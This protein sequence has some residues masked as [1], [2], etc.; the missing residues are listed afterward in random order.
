M[1]DKFDMLARARGLLNAIADS[2]GAS[3]CA[4]IAEL[5][6]ML[7][8]LQEGLK[9]HDRAV[10]ARMEMLNDQIRELTRP[11][12]PE[13]GGEIIGGETYT[14]DLTKGGFED[15]RGAENG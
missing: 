7:R 5:D 14:F 3:R 2:R 8:A 12:E 6:D 9:G 10:Q 1:F 4:R 15:G 13:E 11:K